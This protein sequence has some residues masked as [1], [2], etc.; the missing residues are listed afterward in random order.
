MQL[1]AELPRSLLVVAAAAAVAC[2]DDASTGPIEGEFTLNPQVQWSGGVVEATSQ[3]FAS[4]EEW[5]VLVG[6]DTAT[7]WRVDSETIAF[8][9]P[10]PKL[11]GSTSVDFEAPGTDLRSNV[12]EVVGNAWPVRFLDC[13]ATEPCGVPRLQWWYH[14]FHGVRL[15]GGQLMA[16]FETA[17]GSPGG[18]AFA[19]GVLDDAS[20]VLSWVSDLSAEQMPGLVAPGPTPNGRQWIFDLSPPEVAV[21]PAVWDVGNAPHQV[22]PLGC[23]PDGVAGGY[24]VVELPSGDCLVLTDP[25]DRMPGS[26]TVNGVSPIPGYENIPY[27][28]MAGCATLRTSTGNSW[29]T[30]RSLKGPDFCGSGTSPDGLPAWGVF[31]SAGTLSFASTRYPLWVRGADFTPSG[32]TLWVVGGTPAW[33]LDAWNPATGE[34][35]QE[36]PLEGYSACDDVLVDPFRP[37]LYAACRREG[38]LPDSMVWPSLVVVDRGSATILAVLDPI[39]GANTP[40]MKPPIEL[41][42]GGLSGRIHMTGVWDGTTAPIERG[43]FVVSWDILERM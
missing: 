18:G 21:Q 5:I 27:G 29:T 1:K 34:L 41:A 28:W 12:V 33:S 22:R 4:F 15:A 2:G 38:D 24:E 23:L 39:L 14:Y 17:P 25:G 16:F 37:Y 7:S 36:I 10:N 32:D 30:L 9:L 20:P 42:G 35:V 3:A 40:S 6:G 11:T 26:L 31:T 43:V 8:R 19:F 13:P